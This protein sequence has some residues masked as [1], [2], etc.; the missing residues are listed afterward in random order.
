MK[1][2]KIDSLKKTSWNFSDPNTNKIFNKMLKNSIEFK[3][4]INDQF[5][6]GV[7]TGLNNAFVINEE[8]RA[9]LISE[10]SKSEEIIFPYLSGQEIKRYGVEWKKKYLI[11]A[12]QGIDIS[13]YPA[14][15]KHL[16]LFHKKLQPKKNSKEKIGRKPGKYKWYEIQDTTNYWK[17]FLNKGIIYP[18][19]NKQSNFT[20]SSGNFFLNAKG[21][22][23][24]NDAYWLLAIL[25]S[26]LINFYLKSICPFVRG[27]YYEYNSQYVEK[28]PITLNRK[29]TNQL[30]NLSQEIMKNQ[31][32]IINNKDMQ[33]ELQ[34]NDKLEKMIDDIVYKLYEITDE[35]KAIIES[36]I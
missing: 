20:M 1:Q 33:I 7:T 2:V 28:I 17:I 4:F 34:N 25:N 23:I 36:S 21:Y 9:E 6:R 29:Y 32:K 18:H 12:K 15:K 26:K 22:Q 30:D 11:F 19:F 10:D 24:N 8:K 27:E 31:E 14:I 13:H 5:Y 3:N 16:E 35:E